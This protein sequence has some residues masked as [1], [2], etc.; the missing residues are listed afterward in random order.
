M[1]QCTI[2][3]LDK[4]SCLSGYLE[5][6]PQFTRRY[7]FYGLT[8]FP[9]V[10]FDPETGDSGVQAKYFAAG[11]VVPFAAADTGALATR[12]RGNIL[13]G[14]EGLD[15]LAEGVPA[16]EVIRRLLDKDPL[17]EGRQLGVVDADAIMRIARFVVRLA[18]H[19]VF[20]PVAS[21]AGTMSIEDMG[22]KSLPGPH[23]Q[24]G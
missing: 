8:R 13:H 15:L 16:K 23:S 19:G 20:A 2:I 4:T 11:D 1:L 18:P 21:M 17:G 12:A 14:P 3:T 7:G 10:A 9:I 24:S 5:V 22:W 6:V